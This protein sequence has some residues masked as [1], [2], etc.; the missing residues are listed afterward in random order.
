MRH[1]RLPFLAAAPENV[2]IAPLEPQ[3]AATL[4]RKLHE[5]QEMSRCLGDG[6][7]PRLPA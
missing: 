6:L 3:H 1:E 7:P 5:A 2:W 4:A